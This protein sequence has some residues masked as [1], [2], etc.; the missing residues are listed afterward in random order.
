MSQENAVL[1]ENQKKAYNPLAAKYNFTVESAGAKSEKS[2]DLNVIKP[3]IKLHFLRIG[4]FDSEA[5]TELC[6]APKENNETYED[7]NQLEAIEVRAIK[8]VRFENVDVAVTNLNS[9]YIYLIEE[10][11]FDN[12]HEFQINHGGTLSSIYW[13]KNKENGVYKDFRVADKE[14]K[15]FVVC[16]HGSK[17]WVAFSP[18]QWSAS[19]HKEF[20]DNAEKRKEHMQLI[21]CVGFEKG[22]DS[23]DNL[24]SYEKIQAQ[25]YKED[26]GASNG[27]DKKLKAIHAEEKQQDEKGGNEVLEDTFIVFDDPIGCGEDLKE[28]VSE[29]TLRFKAIIDAI[30]SGE[31]EARAFQRISDGNF[32]APKPEKEYASLFSLAL[33]CYKMVYN[34]DKSILKYD[35]GASGFN[36]F[37]RHSLDPRPATTSFYTGNGGMQTKANNG[38]IGYGVDYEKLEGILGIK[39]RNEKRNTLISYRN[40]LGN[41]LKADYFKKPLDLYL[42]NHKE[43][44]LE[45]RNRV[46][47]I[48]DTLSYHP[49]KFDQHLMLEKEMVKEDQWIDWLFKITDDECSQHFASGTKSKT[50]E[51]VNY[52]P[53]FALVGVAL[54]IDDTLGKK[55]SFSESLVGVYQKNLQYRGGQVANYHSINGV[56]YKS[57]EA[58][59]KLIVKKLN[60]NLKVFGEEMF[61]IRDGDIRLRLQELGVELDPKY[62]TKGKYTGKRADVLRILKESN[63]DGFEYTQVRNGG[64]LKT[65]INVRV[66]EN[67]G[68]VA[69]NK[70]IAKK[71]NIAK[72]VNGKA[73][74]GLFAALEARNFWN[75]SA[76]LTNEGS[77]NNKLDVIKSVVSLADA[78]ANLY[79]SFILSSGKDISK[80]FAKKAARLG[81]LGGVLSAA[82]CFSDSFKAMDKGDMDSGLAL[83]GAGVAF[84]ISTMAGAGIVFA[85]AGPV[86]WIAAAIG[87]GLL[88]V[89]SLLTDSELETVFKNFILSDSY[90]KGF[91]KPANLSPMSYTRNTLLNKAILTDDDYH[92]TL[93]NPSDAQASLLDAIMC[94]EIQFEAKNNTDY[95]YL[96][97]QDN[98]TGAHIESFTQW[99]ATMVFSRFFNHPNQVEPHAFLY[100]DGVGDGKAEEITISKVS[101]IFDT[102][103]QQALQVKFSVP[104]NLK[105]SLSYKSEVVL[106]LR[107]KIDASQSMYFPYNLNKKERYLGVKLRVNQLTY[108]MSEFKENK[109]IVKAPLKNIKNGKAWQ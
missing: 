47:D 42:G 31:D 49:Y 75:A 50:E 40:D 74:N 11:S 60:T 103:N 38:F 52:D 22:A 55:L 67:L 6:S 56:V 77:I 76:K 109:D 97:S 21:D 36:F 14:T 15:E 79:K 12:F 26:I 4:L 28:I 78:S 10:G 3:G 93:M 62:V 64:K 90:S 89:A 29:K 81:V 27:F 44:M 25:F 41:F 33:T 82:W 24:Y 92:E 39:E 84:S 95:S 94:K 66:A 5:E 45:G 72:I 19:Y 88:I 7:G 71:I 102:S 83:I 13:D 91:P 18:V 98:P 108:S 57:L 54:N 69:D 73:F 8:G 58:K 30:E 85:A 9:G 100:A 17:F 105:E 107:L 59:Q 61:E 53:L 96:R 32:E 16:P 48:L 65:T 106:A 68:T 87:V 1:E 63:P 86:G 43:Y 35:G 99:T 20:L 104:N 70:G 101:K 34:D 23:K 37:D 51:F 46:L 80:G 2:A